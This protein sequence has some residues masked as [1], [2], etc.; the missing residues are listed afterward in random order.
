MNIKTIKKQT[1]FY[2]SGDNIPPCGHFLTRLTSLTFILYRKY[3]L[4]HARNY[5]NTFK[6]NLVAEKHK[7]RRHVSFYSGNN[8]FLNFFPLFR[9]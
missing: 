1:K 4:K 7:A 8:F 5:K 9:Q 3:R 6:I 2:N